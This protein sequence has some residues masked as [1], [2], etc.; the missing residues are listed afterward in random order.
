MTSDIVSKLVDANRILAHEGV[1]D[2]YGHVSLRHPE[3][4]DRY[5]LSR[6]RSPELVEADDIMEFTL[7]GTPLD[8]RGRT[9]YLERFIHGAVYERRPEIVAVV[10]N[11]AVE[12]LP[13]GITGV[14]LRPV[15]H[16]CGR[17]GH[18]VPVWDIRERFGDTNLL[19]TDMDQGRDL[20]R[21]LDDR[22]CALMRGH[23]CV[24][25]GISLEEAVLTAIYLMLN[26]RV[27]MD[28]LRLGEIT[29]LSPGEVDLTSQQAKPK[30][31]TERAWEYYRARIPQRAGA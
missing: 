18:E 22:Y 10:H 11:H 30:L 17:I 28:A 12:V 26:A 8:A 6:S 4:P 9:P 13:F 24:V 2:A 20:A 15:A 21:G 23:G 16:T 29:A 19:V 14:P 1:V 25:A 3:R 31:A 7:D 5:L 27:Q